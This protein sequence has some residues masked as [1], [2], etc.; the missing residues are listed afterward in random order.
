MENAL[1]DIRTLFEP[2]SIAIIGA[3]HSPNK[4]GYRIVE[5][6]IGS[7][8]PGRIFPVN[9]RGGELLGL[10]VYGSLEDIRDEIDLAILVIPAKL[11]FQA[12]KDC[13]RKKVRILVV[14]TSGFSEVGNFEEEREM[15]SYARRHGMRVLGPNIFG[16]Y[17][18]VAPV[19]ATFGPGEVAEGNVALIT[20]S[21]AIG[22]AMFGKTRIENIGLSAV[23][24]VG[25]KSDIDE[26][27]LLEYL[28]EHEG[29]R[30]IL[31]YIEGIK[32]GEKL[33]TALKK[34]TPRKPVIVIKSGS[35]KRGA[36][37]AASHTGSLAGADEIF[38]DVMKQCGVLRAKSIQEALVWC[39]Y[40]STAPLPK[41]ENAVIITNGGGLG[42]LAADACEKYGVNLYDDLETLD[43]TFSGVVPEFGSVKNPIDLTG[44][45]TFGDYEDAV[46]AAIDNDDIHSMICLGCQTAFFNGRELERSISAM[47]ERASGKKPLTFSFLGGSMIE[48]S[49]RKLKLSGIPVFSD[50]YE[51]ISCFGALYS[52]YRNRSHGMSPDAGLNCVSRADVG[53]DMNEDMDLRTMELGV[54]HARADG[55]TFLLANEAADLMNAAGIRMPAAKVARNLQECIDAATEIGYP[56]VMKVVSRDII[57]KSDAGGVALNLENRQE[58]MDAYQAIIHSCKR[59]RPDARIEGIEVSEM[60]LKGL[61]TIIGA[62][63]DRAF[64]PIVMFGLGGIYVEVMKDVA[65]RALPVNNGEVRSMIKQIRSYPLLLGVRGE[66]KKDVD[67]IA[68]TI[69]RIGSI[70]R[71]IDSISDIEINPLV[72]YKEG[73]G[74]LAL[75]ARILLTSSTRC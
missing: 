56:V 58:V 57:H 15:V 17:S 61:E 23:V 6:I 38:S 8:F 69:M 63:R 48:D 21:G 37:A 43:T 35:S 50:V 74:C 12:V 72:V 64:G 10:H 11:A 22:V 13:A 24:S 45:A 34:I 41:G 33:V 16:I 51:A 7:G 65:F 44:P 30:V 42:V 26:A 40:L 55:R 36:V 66:R 46:G 59:Y 52:V 67:G 5:N 47:H 2:E 54:Q 39:K 27:D 62:R 32:N 19:N 9:P 60:I 4:I 14:I 3:S 70:I 68:D 53:T 49:T 31:M 18:S 28:G 71:E 29:T 75:D 20:Q 73:K 1:P 25:N